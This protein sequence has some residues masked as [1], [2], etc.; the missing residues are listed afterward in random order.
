MADEQHPPTMDPEAER[1]VL[2]GLLLDNTAFSLVVPML[3]P[4]DFAMPAHAAIYDAMLSLSGRELPVDVVTLASELRAHDRLNTVGGAQFLGELTDTLPT[5]A[6]IVAHARIVR[7]LARTRRAID[8]CHVAVHKLRTGSPLGAA[9]TALG[10]AFDDADDTG[11]AARVEDDINDLFATTYA[12]RDGSEKPLPTPWS[13]VDT[14]LGGGWWPG[15]YVLVGGTGIGKTQ[16]AVQA[17][18]KAAQAGVRV[19]YLA[20]ELSRRDLAARVVGVLSGVSWSGLLRGT[21]SDDDLVRAQNAR[22]VVEGLPL[23]TECGPPYGYGA[24]AM[25]SRAWALRSTFVVLDYL[26]LCSGRSGEDLR[27]G[28]ARAAYTARALARDLGAVVLVLSSTAREN[29]GRLEWSEDRDPSDLV[30]TG[31]ESGEVEYAADGVL[32]LARQKD[33]AKARERS[34]VIAKNRHG[35]LG[36]V[37]LRWNGTAFSSPDQDGTFRW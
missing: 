24:E 15:M 14:L 2:G 35:P 26:Q 34:L 25:A 11:P 23:H 17:S 21:L 10:T 36:S 22:R 5:A 7:D 33:T 4:A 31:K 27:I 6:H 29:Y 8:A 32:V 16:W 18:V 37:D 19:L 20:L 30:G 12:R 9:H 3:R 1:A 13:Q 28:I